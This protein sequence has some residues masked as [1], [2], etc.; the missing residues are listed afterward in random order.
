MTGTTRVIVGLNGSLSS[1]AALYRA[2]DEAARRTATLVPLTAWEPTDRDSLRPLSELE[3]AARRRLDTTFDQAYGGY[4]GGLVH[5]PL[6]I[7]GPAGP[8]LV[9][10]AGPDDLI[11]VGAGGHSRLDHL[12]HGSV[13]RHCRTH[14]PCPV[15][16]VSP[17]EL[18]EKLELT[19]RHGAPV[20]L[21]AG[22]SR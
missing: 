13:T 10:A 8:A 17:S 12:L 20:P 11:V 2:V 3:H 5:H 6:V 18:L 14:A 15:I 22:G 4:P 16:T 19:A 7:R 1:L 9:A 21:A